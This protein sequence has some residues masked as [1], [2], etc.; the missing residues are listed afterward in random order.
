MESTQDTEFLPLLEECGIMTMD[1]NLEFYSML[2][3]SQDICSVPTEWDAGSDP[4]DPEMLIHWDVCGD[5]WTDAI[6]SAPS[7]ETCAL[8]EV[9][10]GET[11]AELPPVVKREAKERAPPKKQRFV[12]PAKRVTCPHHGCG[13]IFNYKSLW[14]EH[15]RVHTGERPFVCDECGASYTTKN[16]LKVH[17]RSHTGERP[18][19]CTFEDCQFTA[20]QASDLKY[21]LLIHKKP[22]KPTKAK[23]VTRSIVCEECQRRFRSEASL[24]SHRQKMPLCHDGKF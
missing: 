15:N 18:F 19:V 3:G 12:D 4:L 13:K 11:G 8:F 21:H 14:E 24:V 17:A 22:K 9:E 1:P 6:S 20:K 23:T 2:T 5:A 7:L 16:R 10:T